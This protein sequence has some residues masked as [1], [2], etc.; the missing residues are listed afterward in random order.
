MDT[1]IP[2]QLLADIV[3]LIHFGIV[4]FV[5][6]G[7]LLIV[8]GNMLTW[9]WVNHL[10]FRILHLAA[11]AVVIAESWLGITCPLTTLESWL[12]IQAGASPYRNSF[13]EHWIQSVLFYDAPSWV[14]TIAY[15]LFGLFVA[16]AWWLF[17]PWCDKTRIEDST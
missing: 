1:V 2:Y 9:H 12:R 5:I 7:L 3:L 8:A 17:P 4:L 10:W 14:F 6:G 15:T 11:I 13:I 16:L